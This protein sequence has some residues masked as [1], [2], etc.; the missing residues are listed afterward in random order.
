MD[1]FPEWY[2]NT[3]HSL[4]FSPAAIESATTHTLRLTSQ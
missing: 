1:Q 2:R 3:T 4:P